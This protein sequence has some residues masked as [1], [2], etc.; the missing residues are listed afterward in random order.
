MVTKERLFALIEALPPEAWPDAEEALEHLA[1]P[2]DDEPET[3]EERAM[4]AE[5]LEDLRA[6]RVVSWDAIK[7]TYNYPADA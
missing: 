5:A 3:D 6:G 2:V 7:R 4:I 1:V